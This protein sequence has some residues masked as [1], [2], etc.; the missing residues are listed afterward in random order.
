MQ[1]LGS[2]SLQSVSTRSD[3]TWCYTWA[4]KTLSHSAHLSTRF[5][6]RSLLTTLGRESSLDFLLHQG[7]FPGAPPC[8]EYDHTY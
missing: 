5:P 1:A 2:V 7:P 8:L 4:P 3:G 6:F